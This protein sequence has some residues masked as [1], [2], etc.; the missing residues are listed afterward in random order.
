MS[1][2]TLSPISRPV[3]LAA[4]PQTAPRY[5]VSAKL[6]S[7][8][9]VQLG[10]PTAT[11][12]LVALMDMQAVMGG[13]A[14]H[15]GGPAAFAEIASA[16]YGVAFAQSAEQGRPWYDSFHLINDAGHCENGLYAL[17]ANYGF[18]DLTIESL[19]GFRSI[20]SPLTGHGESHIW[21]QG[22]YLSNGPLGSSLPQSQGLAVADALSGKKRVTVT[23]ISDGAC[24][25]G[26]A[27]E[28]LASIP[29]LASKG[30]LAPFVLVISDNNTKLSGRIDEQSFS[31]NPTFAALKDLGWKVISVEDGHDLQA[32]VTTFE[33]AVEEAQKNPAVPVAIH[34]KTIKGKGTKKTEESASGAHGF[35]LKSPKELP[36]F[37]GEIYAGR[38]V[39]GEFSVWVEE[40]IQQ[41]ANKKKS[42]GA[43]DVPNE[44]VQVGVAQAL[45]EKRKQGLPVVSISS[46]L[47]G[48][49]GV[50]AFQKEFPECS[51]DVGIAESNMVSVGSGLGKEGFIPV[52]DTFAQFGVT[53]GALPLTMASLSE[54]PVIAIFSHI[55]F[56]DAAD[57]ASHQALCYLAMVSSIP[58][59][60][61]HLLSTSKDAYEL[62][63]QAV[64]YFAAEMKAGRTPN[65]QIFFLG[66]ENF[67]QRVVAATESYRL[68]QSKIIYDNSDQYKKSI[69]ITAGGAPLH[70]A[71]LAAKALE[72]ENVGAVVVQSTQV[73][74]SQADFFKPLLDK[75]QGRLITVDDHQSLGGLGTLLIHD[76]TAHRIPLQ[77]KGLGVNGE[78]GQSAYE[79]DELYHKHGIDSEAIVNAA[80]NL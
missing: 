68:G 33:Q 8:K 49:T 14:S 36:E 48:S 10:D 5:A 56:Q 4:N 34:A 79:A 28:S 24:M 40:M 15:F 53:K 57:G 12:G 74:S 25:E 65:S 51:I 72:K 26:E 3:H 66:R 19:K 80:V 37:L 17:K 2:S 20:Q 59:T 41:E 7:G 45:I 77:W 75:T 29:G 38:E 55:G 16:I 13:A 42:N 73:N 39:P 71:L 6:K 52:V 62:V 11:R 78:F 46:D 1:E 47:P 43:S 61:A 70:Q 63:G 9:E 27:R 35:P 50:A 21:P 64:D 67:P 18:A 23:M 60:D 54:G 31:M 76:L 69:V 32:M 58:N 44:K 30:K 22:V